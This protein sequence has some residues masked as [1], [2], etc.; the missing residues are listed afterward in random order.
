MTQIEALKAIA[1][2]D[3]GLLRPQAVVDAARPESSPLHGAF[4]W[5]DTEAADK[6][7]I[8]Q[9]QQLIRSFRVEVVCNRTKVEVPVFIGVSTD[10]TEGK[11]EN[12][13]R[14]ASDVAQDGDLLAIAE[15]D[16][17]EQLQGL[18]KRLG[19]LKRLDD[20]WTAIDTHGK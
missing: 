8:L 7:R 1:K 10:R 14:L 4:C 15:H 13:Y 18:R 20:I 5:D 6:Y 16:A 2:R 17:L 9:A 12:P 3:G 11:A 19:Y